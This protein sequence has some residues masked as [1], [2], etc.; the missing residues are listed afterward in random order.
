LL[1]LALSACDAGNPAPALQTPAARAAQAQA[2][3][4]AM[5]PRRAGPP[6]IAVLA[7]NA[8]TEMTDFL[9][10]HAVLRRS[11]VAEVH[12]IAPQPGRVALY[13][14]LAVEVTEDLAAF[15]R[16]HPSGADYVIVPAMRDDDDPA[17]LRWLERQAQLGARIIGICVGTL[18]V[19][20]A[21]LLD[22][23]RFATHWY[24]RST[25]LRRHP[26]AVHVPHQRYVVDR[27]VA[28]TTGITASIP[29]M[30]A[31]VEAIGGR[32]RAR[33][34]ATELGASAWTPEH[35]STPFRLDAGRMASYLLNRIAFWRREDWAASIE[36]GADDVALALAADAWSRTGRIRLHAV[37]ASGPIHLRSGLK[38]LAQP[39][40]QSLPQLPLAPGLAPLAQLDRTLC[41]IGSR[42]GRGRLDWVMLELEY[43]P[44]S[45]PCAAAPA[46]PAA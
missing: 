2:F 33:A 41:E 22:Q 5:K 34:L 1:A 11:G 17:I 36:P 14:A 4:D 8:G 18:V 30:L 39:R 23:R 35:D 32:D 6:V 27:D 43:A 40:A 21:G 3:I 29:T 12:A 20:R 44:G 16:A 15:D 42:Y 28:T 7:L 10:P 25:L 19:G 9:V 45:L 46:R 26:G 31:L 13:P 37:A 24:Y 38:L